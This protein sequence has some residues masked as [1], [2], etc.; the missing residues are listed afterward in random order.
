MSDFDFK[1]QTEEGATFE[2]WTDGNAVGFKVTAEGMPD[3]YVYLNPSGATYAGDV[4]DSDV[5]TYHGE[6]G[7]PSEDDAL[8]YIN[9]W[10]EEDE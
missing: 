3:R 2:P 1:V 7:D 10:D 8:S 5:F 6:H 9:I 4:R